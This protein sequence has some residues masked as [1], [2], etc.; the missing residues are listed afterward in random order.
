MGRGQPKSTNINFKNKIRR[1]VIPVSKREC[2]HESDLHVLISE[3]ATCK[4]DKRKWK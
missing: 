3:T 4:T 2:T 1:Q